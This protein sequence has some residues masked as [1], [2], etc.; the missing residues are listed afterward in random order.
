[1]EPSSVLVRA[2]S[3][4]EHEGG[5]TAALVRSQFDLDVPI[6][7][8][9][10]SVR[11]AAVHLVTGTALAADI[12]AGMPSPV[13]S[14]DPPALAAENAQRIA[15]IPGGDPEVLAGLL[16]AETAR[17]LAVTA[18]RG[19]DDEVLWHGGRRLGLGD[20]VCLS[21]GEQILH[22]HDMAGAL[23]VRWPI[24]QD[25]ARLVL[26]GYGRVDDG[27]FRL[28]PLITRPRE[29]ADPVAALL[30]GSGRGDRRGP[31]GGRRRR[32]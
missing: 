18:G 19:D 5:R 28:A 31:A 27:E 20:L 14:L 17:L 8:S 21:L 29:P 25:H 12:A 4:L 22:A 10:W 13:A 6:P 7:G 30:A 23:G 9:A 11:E 1:M 15:D 2:R 32:R 16:G 26:H 3:A 24:R